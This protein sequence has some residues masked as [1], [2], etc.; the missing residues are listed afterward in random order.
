MS[1]KSG[2]Y[3][4]IPSEDPDSKNKSYPGKSAQTTTIV[5]TAVGVAISVIILGLLIPT[6]VFA[7]Q[8]KSSSSSASSLEM[9]NV[10]PLDQTESLVSAQAGIQSYKLVVVGGGIG[11]MHTAFRASQKLP[12]GQVALFEATNRV[13]GII[14]DF[15]LAG[16]T[17][18]HPLRIGG[19]ALRF[20]R[21]TMV[22]MRNLANELGIPLYFTGF[23]SR[24]QLLGRE[25]DG[26]YLPDV[27][28]GWQLPAI[29]YGE[30]PED[31][32]LSA[33][34]YLFGSAQGN[35]V[36]VNPITGVDDA[37]AGNHP[38]Q[39]CGEFP[40]IY[41]MYKHYF[42][43][44]Y[45]NFICSVNVGFLGDCWGGHEPCGYLDW[46]QREWNTAENG[47][48]VGGVSELCRR[49]RANG[50]ANGA[51]FFYSERVLKVDKSGSKFVIV[52]SKRVVS[53]EEVV[54]NLS[55]EELK[56]IGGSIPESI[57]LKPQSKAPKAVES[58][59][60]AATFPNA[61]WETAELT[62]PDSDTRS[63]RLLQ[64]GGGCFN[65]LEIHNH[66]YNFL[67]NTIRVVYTDYAC[68]ENWRSIIAL[69]DAEVKKEIMRG[70][71]NAY[72]S[73]TIPQPT[74]VYSKTEGQ[75]WFYHA[76][77]TDY[78]VQ[79]ISDWAKMPLG[80]SSR[81]CLAHQAYRTVD[82]GWAVSSVRLSAQCLNRFYPQ[83]FSESTLEAWETAYGRIEPG[84]T[85]EIET[86]SPLG[87]EI[88][89]FNSSTPV[90][91]NVA[92]FTYVAS[93]S[94]SS[95]VGI[96]NQEARKRPEGH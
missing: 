7:A 91:W 74:A 13:C 77:G 3:S 6:L 45:A 96:Q 83:Q 94:G 25:G 30:D 58:L 32:E 64:A 41:S 36:D 81:V 31:P 49:M 28:A 72:P 5:L 76:P 51:K 86:P 62:T 66:P 14:E 90:T 48:P 4:S 17:T 67:H 33:L 85:G 79:E 52:T 2:K 56:K 37:A 71:K 61:W 78:T 82:S 11:G 88:F 42:G 26:S 22:P 34:L 53:A 63:Y 29:P 43:D 19:C 69:G 44:V 89:E 57:L 68:K 39:K 80:Q 8:A 46:Y 23:K 1:G 47:Y 54:F 50:T 84:W 9:V 59:T 55:P 18:A 65:R 35:G 20:N 16:S 15:E 73:L 93:V 10:L 12:T 92:P 95:V 38:T 60:I 21:G 70:L 87:N 75:A 27:R 40:D 24:W